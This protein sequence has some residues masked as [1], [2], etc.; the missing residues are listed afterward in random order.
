M[1][2]SSLGPAPTTHPDCLPTSEGSAGAD[3]LAPTV[4]VTRPARAPAMS[5]AALLSRVLLRT[6]K[7]PS[8]G[9][10]QT[11]RTGRGLA[12]GSQVVKIGKHF[13]PDKV[14]PRGGPGCTSPRPGRGS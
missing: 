9:F 8:G 14:R 6:G 3:G 2:G 7:G 4:A 12:L 5:L 11:L 1:V 10:L 13:T